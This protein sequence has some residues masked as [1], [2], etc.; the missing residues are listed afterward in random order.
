MGFNSGFKGLTSPY[1]LHRP[2]GPLRVEQT[3]TRNRGRRIVNRTRGPPGIDLA[4]PHHTDWNC[5]HV[6][7][8]ENTGQS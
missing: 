8:T 3:A 7:F 1:Y 2:D 6:S 4:T 5:L